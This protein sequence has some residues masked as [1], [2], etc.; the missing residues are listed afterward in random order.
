MCDSF[1]GE[2]GMW[3]KSRNA[4]L[5]A[6]GARMEAGNRFGAPRDSDGLRGHRLLWLQ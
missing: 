5:Q 2:I 1:L 3:R 6:I 4:D